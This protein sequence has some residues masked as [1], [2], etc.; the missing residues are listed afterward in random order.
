MP[1]Y[2]VAVINRPEK[3]KPECDDDVPL[4]LIGPVEVL[5]DSEDLFSAV[6][7]AVEYNRG[8]Q[9]RVKNRWAVVVDPEGTGQHWPAAR[10]CTPL[11][12]KVVAVWWPDGWEPLAPLDVPNCIHLTQEHAEG[13]WLDYDRA[14]AAVLALNRQCMDH[15]G[16]TWYVVGAVENEPISRT[17]CRDSSGTAATTEVRPLHVITPAKGGRGDCTHCPAEALP[18]ANDDSPSRPLTITTRRVEPAGA[19]VKS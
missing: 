5:A 8:E 13:D 6:G 18:C 4:K 1:K 12:H 7:Q 2:Q 9:S 16:E 17:V 10:L 14:E 15:P 19:C 11:T 3:W